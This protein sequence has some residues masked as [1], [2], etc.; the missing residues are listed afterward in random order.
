MRENIASQRFSID[1]E[2]DQITGQA[3]TT[4]THKQQT[5]TEMIEYQSKRKRFELKQ[6]STSRLWQQDAMDSLL[7]PQAQMDIFGSVSLE[8]QKTWSYY[9]AKATRTIE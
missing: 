8:Q 7:G 2:R 4:L 6:A 1:C 9:L 5:V 3:V